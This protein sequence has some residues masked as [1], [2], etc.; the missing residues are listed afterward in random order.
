[1]LRIA[2]IGLHAT[3]RIRALFRSALPDSLR[4]IK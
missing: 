1:M 2:P 3:R 4:G